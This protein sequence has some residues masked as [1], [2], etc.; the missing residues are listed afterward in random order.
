MV[1]PLEYIGGIVVIL[2]WIKVDIIC[3]MDENAMC[4]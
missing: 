3:F 1:D 4:T 2:V